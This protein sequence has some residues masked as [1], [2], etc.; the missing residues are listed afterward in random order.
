ML[1]QWLRR[2]LLDLEAI[3][4]RQE[5]VSELYDDHFAR[6]EI[7]ALLKSISDLERL[8]MRVSN[9][10]ATPK[11]LRDMANSLTKVLFLEKAAHDLN[12]S[13]FRYLKYVE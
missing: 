11:C 6:N 2:P 7:R 13:F 10:K 1:R 4:Y 3:L 8:G 5:A 12:I 9:G